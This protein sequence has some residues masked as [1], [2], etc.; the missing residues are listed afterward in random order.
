MILKEQN[1][2]HLSKTIEKFTIQLKLLYN[3]FCFNDWLDGRVVMQRPA[4]PLTPV[5]FRI[6][7]PFYTDIQFF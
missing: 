5:R 6:Q 4:K 1:T 2:T 7:P 3:A